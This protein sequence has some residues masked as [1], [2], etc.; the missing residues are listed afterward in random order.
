VPIGVSVSGH[1]HRTRT[2]HLCLF[3]VAWGW[4][5]WGPCSRPTLW[6]AALFPVRQYT[7]ISIQ[8]V[9]N[10]IKRLW[11]IIKDTQMRVYRDVQRLY[12]EMCREYGE[13]IHRV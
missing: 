13:A 3:P 5:R 9:W 11:N 1:T 7:Q 8:R 2:Q 12:T 10:I 6:G 4:S